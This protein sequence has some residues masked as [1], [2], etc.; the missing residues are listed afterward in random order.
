M[1]GPEER[2]EMKYGQKKIRSEDQGGTPHGCYH[3]LIIKSREITG[4][5][6]NVEHIHVGLS[7]DLAVG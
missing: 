5:S 7:Y 4:A 1:R 3:Y 6:E 2:R